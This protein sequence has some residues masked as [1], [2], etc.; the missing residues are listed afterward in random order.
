MKIE[1]ITI[2]RQQIS[3][4][5]KEFIDINNARRLLRKALQF[6]P[7]KEPLMN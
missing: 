6:T 4:S 2:E 1:S 3:F 7:D 5:D